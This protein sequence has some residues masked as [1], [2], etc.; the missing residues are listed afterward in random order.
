RGVGQVAGDDR[1]PP[2]ECY[3]A[4]GAG[5]AGDVLG[6]GKA[7]VGM[8]VEGG[9]A[10]DYKVVIA[11]N[12]DAKEPG[13]IDAAGRRDKVADRQVHI[14]GA[15]RGG[16]QHRAAGILQL[17]VHAA[18]LVQQDR[19]GVAVVI[20]GGDVQKV[21]A[22]EIGQDQVGETAVA[23]PGGKIGVGAEA[24]AAVAEQ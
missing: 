22:G 10:R 17:H 1:G 12:A 16:G 18:D 5:R 14:R 23:A 4:E 8:E 6:G 9:V 7:V 3:I 19:D 21:I 2:G 24:A 20:R 11:V 13:V 15:R